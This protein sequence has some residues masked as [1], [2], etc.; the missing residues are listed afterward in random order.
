[1]ENVGPGAKS[2]LQQGIHVCASR[3]ELVVT[4]K[5]ALTVGNTGDHC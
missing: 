1:M 5:S 2:D 4:F 3:G